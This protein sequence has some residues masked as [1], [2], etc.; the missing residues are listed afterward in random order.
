MGSTFPAF[1]LGLGIVFDQDIGG[2]YLFLYEL[3]SEE[4]P[5]DFWKRRGFGLGNDNYV[6]F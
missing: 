5:A 3:G 6:G 2:G 1:G 4:G